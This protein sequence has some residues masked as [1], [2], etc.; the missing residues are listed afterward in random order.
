ALL[1]LTAVTSLVDAISFLSLGRVFTANMTG[2][3]AFIAFAVAGAPELSIARS[4]VA[5]VAFLV[6][7]IV[8]GR[9]MARTT[10]GKP[11]GHVRVDLPASRS[12]DV[13]SPCDGTPIVSKFL[14]FRRNTMG[15]NPTLSTS[16]LSSFQ[17][18]NENAQGH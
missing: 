17:S 6:G 15:L 10:N 14:N 4:V 1:G 12:D 5:L 7:A 2:N 8:G 3:V 11:R 13:Q 16:L 18:N 9:I